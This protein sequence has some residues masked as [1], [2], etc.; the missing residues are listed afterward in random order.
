MASRVPVKWRRASQR[1]SRG[2]ASLVISSMTGAETTAARFVSRPFSWRRWATP[3]LTPREMAVETHA[4]QPKQNARTSQGRLL[5]RP[6][7]TKVAMRS[8][9][10]TNAATRP[11][12]AA[13][14]PAPS[15]MAQ[16]RTMRPPAKTRAQPTAVR[17]RRR[18]RW[19]ATART[20]PM[21]AS[22][23]AAVRTRTSSRVWSL[24]WRG[25]SGRARRLAR[26]RG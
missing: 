5:W 23:P 13:S 24:T 3:V 20:A 7:H 12:P 16:P 17:G 14:A 1:T 10:G 18:V 4:P 15:T 19:P 6:S 8:G 11:T 9:A 26:P 21:R 22:A 25:P 2:P